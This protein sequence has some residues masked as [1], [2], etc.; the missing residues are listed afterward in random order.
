MPKVSKATQYLSGFPL[1]FLGA[2]P[3]PSD[4]ETTHKTHKCQ[5]PYLKNKNWLYKCKDIVTCSKSHF[6]SLHLKL[7]GVGSFKVGWDNSEVNIRTLHS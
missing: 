6:N 4:L 1:P 2:A 5:S 7:P 3:N